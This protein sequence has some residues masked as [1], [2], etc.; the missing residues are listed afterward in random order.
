MTVNLPSTSR[1]KLKG[2]EAVSYD[3]YWWYCWKKEI[4]VDANSLAS[5]GR[6]PAVK[7]VDKRQHWVSYK[8]LAR[9]PRS[10]IRCLHLKHKCYNQCLYSAL[11]VHNA[12]FPHRSLVHVATL[13]QE[14][15]LAGQKGTVGVVSSGGTP[16]P[17]GTSVFIMCTI[18]THSVKLSIYDLMSGTFTYKCKCME[19]LFGKVKYCL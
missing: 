11:L 19:Q 5:V 7:C 9:T 15:R 1:Q 10:I 13:A 6:Y 18:S 8:Y 16:T 14:T 4:I 2:M 17:A 3:R 12:I